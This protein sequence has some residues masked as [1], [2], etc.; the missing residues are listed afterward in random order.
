MPARKSEARPKAETAAT[1]PANAP[2]RFCYYHAGCPDGMGAA[3]SVHQAWKGEGTFMARGHDDVQLV[4]VSS[5][6]VIVV[7]RSM[8]DVDVNM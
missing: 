5:Q 2:K 7:S 6:R 4:H 1:T 8:G 3:W